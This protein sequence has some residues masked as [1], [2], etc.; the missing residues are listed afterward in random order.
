MVQGAYSLSELAKKC[1]LWPN[2]IVAAELGVWGVLMDYGN[3]STWGNATAVCSLAMDTAADLQRFF[4]EVYSLAPGLFV[5]LAMLTVWSSVQ[6]AISL[7]CMSVLM[8]AVSQASNI[9]PDD[10]LMTDAMI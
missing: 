7:Y 5:T 1:K 9:S 10:V 6:S 4:L 3:Q 8:R 2:H